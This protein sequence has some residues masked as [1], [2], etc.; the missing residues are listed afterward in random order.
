VM[1]IAP[2]VVCENWVVNGTAQPGEASNCKI[3]IE[4][5]AQTTQRPGSKIA[6]IR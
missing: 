6:L 5:P 1:K 2:V 3:A 4:R